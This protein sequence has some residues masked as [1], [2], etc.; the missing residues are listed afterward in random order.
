MAYYLAHQRCAAALADM[1]GPADAAQP[2]MVAPAGYAQPRSH[3]H[4][5]HH[6]FM[7]TWL[8]CC[9]A[10]PLHHFHMHQPMRSSMCPWVLP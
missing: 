2:C 1:G 4:S 9:L 5:H 7:R 8:I 6:C 10:L 3:H